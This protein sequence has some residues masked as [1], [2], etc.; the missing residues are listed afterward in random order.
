[1]KPLAAAGVAIAAVAVITLVGL[2]LQQVIPTNPLAF[3]L[4]VPP[5]LFTALVGGFWA[6]LLA[7][8]LG[9]LSA[10]YFFRRPYLTFPDEV[11]ELYPL[12][13]YLLIGVGI[14]IM[15]GRLA[16]ARADVQRREREFQTLFNLTP[17][18]IA[19]ASEPGCERITVNPSFAE[20]L[21]VPSGGNASLSAP[22]EERPGFTVLQDGKPVAREDLP[23]QLAA[24]LGREVRN[25]ELDI[26]HPDGAT[27]S[28]YEYAAP[29]FD[30]EG[31]V[32][33]AVGAFLDITERKRVEARLRQLVKENELL[34]REA[35]EASRLKDEFLAT[36]S[37]ELRTPLNALLGWIQLVRSG[38]LSAEKRE[39]AFAAIERSAQLQAQLTSDL[40]D[41]SGAITGKLRLTIEPTLVTP[42]VDDVIDSL[43]SAADSKGVRFTHRVNVN[44][45]LLLDAARLQQILWNLVS[46]AIKFTPR[47]GDI[48]LRVEVADGDLVIE[49]RDSGEGIAPD[50][51][52]HVFQ[53]FRQADA[54][55]ARRH[56][57]LGLGLA[58]V[59]DLAELHGG[60]AT[61]ESEGIRRGAT[62]TVRIPA[63]R[64]I[65]HVEP[66]RAGAM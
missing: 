59:K 64:P 2:G 42:L 36:L 58:I 12:S 28:L 23:L 37:H 14:G 8:V 45:R 34:Y 60:Q 29:L 4:F 11:G 3:L 26:V 22:P 9:G 20:L 1:V 7:T 48:A 38:H 54:G 35:Q 63:R 52:P 47:G 16:R 39:R 53:P 33:G 43:R 56:G 51:L 27:V 6:T 46:N 30:E 10:E 62:F 40:L 21:R 25:V 65:E 41:V 32:S 61:V 5:I 15:A 24:R 19:I 17:I 66:A 55:V 49:V 50:F 31:Q 18:G 13:L 44:G 57:G